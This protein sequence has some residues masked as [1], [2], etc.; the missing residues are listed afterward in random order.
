M[1]L[2]FGDDVSMVSY[3]RNLKLLIFSN[4]TSDKQMTDVCIKKDFEVKKII[5]TIP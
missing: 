1:F 2:W 3:E 5:D 4:L